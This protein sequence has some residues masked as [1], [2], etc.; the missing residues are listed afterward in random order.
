MEETWVV[1]RSGSPVSGT[2]LPPS[3]L[4]DPRNSFTGHLILESLFTLSRTI[5]VVTPVSRTQTCLVPYTPYFV[6]PG[7]TSTLLGRPGTF[8]ISSEALCS[9][10]Y[11]MII[12]VIWS[13]NE[14]QL[15]HG[16]C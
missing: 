1:T 2:S 9:T 6:G 12:L 7:S 4:V 10:R 8:G 11:Q 5:F 15:I 13:V 16:T 3:S 14:F